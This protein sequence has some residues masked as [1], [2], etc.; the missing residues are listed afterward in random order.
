MVPYDLDVWAPIKCLRNQSSK[1]WHVSSSC[2]YF[3]PKAFLC[4]TVS[5]P[6]EFPLGVN[7]RFLQHIDWSP[8][9]L[10]SFDIVY[11]RLKPLNFY[12]STLGGLPLIYFLSK[13]VVYTPYGSVRC[14]NDGVSATHTPTNN[15]SRL[16]QDSCRRRGQLK[17]FFLHSLIFVKV[18][19]V[20]RVGSECGEKGEWMALQKW[21]QMKDGVGRW[22]K[23][24]MRIR[25]FGKR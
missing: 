11:N 18:C 8:T 15:V 14:Q 21:V 5:T 16:L 24:S 3:Y 22:L 4:V 20:T 12:L 10:W 19:G 13:V 6:Q 2:Q 25:C 7:I 17:I 23:T 9:A 1:C